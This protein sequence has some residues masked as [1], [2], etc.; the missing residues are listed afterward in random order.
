MP[1]LMKRLLIEAE[2]VGLARAYEGNT[3]LADSGHP[4]LADVVSQKEGFPVDHSG[5]LAGAENN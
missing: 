2:D 3:V 1:A 5:G 4:K